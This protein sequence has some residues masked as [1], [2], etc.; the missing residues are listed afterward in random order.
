M[1]KMP[2]QK[3]PLEEERNNQVVGHFPLNLWRHFHFYFTRKVLKNILTQSLQ[4]PF[5]DFEV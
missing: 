2:Q 5:T 4:Q 3:S 1:Q